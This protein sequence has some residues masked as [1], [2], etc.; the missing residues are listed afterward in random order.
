MRKKSKFKFK[1]QLSA[2]NAFISSPHPKTTPII[3][4][5]LNEFIR[6]RKDD[7][8]WIN[9]VIRVIGLESEDLKI[10]F[11]QQKLNLDKS[12][13]QE[14]LDIIIHY[15]DIISDYHNKL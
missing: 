11:A 8:N 10:W 14:D 6:G 4:F 3:G 9:L 1:N 7:T 2:Y 12:W 5:W 13:C 15:S